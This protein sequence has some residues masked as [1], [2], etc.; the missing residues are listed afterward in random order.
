MIIIFDKNIQNQYQKLYRCSK[1]DNDKKFV[2]LN[3]ESNKEW[4]E[5]DCR[6]NSFK[7][8]D[9]TTFSYQI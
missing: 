5:M 1:Y 8:G 4:K 2:I 3:N 7:H 6:R 9:K